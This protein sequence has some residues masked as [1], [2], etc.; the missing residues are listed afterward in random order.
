MN[1]ARRNERLFTSG[2]AGSLAAALL[3]LGPPGSDLAAHV[4]QRAVY[5][6]HGFVLW[7]NF[8]Y[9]GRYSFVTYSVLYYPLAALLGIKLLAVLIVAASVLGFAAVVRH[10]WGA[11]STWSIRVF[12]LVWAC[13]VVSA[14]FPF[15]LGAAFAFAALVALQH[16]RRVLFAAAALATLASS[17]LAFVLLVVV[18]VGVGLARR[19][20]AASLALP[21]SVLV[22]IAAAGV[23][24]QRMFPAHG[25][26]PFSA[27]EFAAVAAFCLIGL[28]LTWTISGARILRWFFAAYL[29][30][31]CA[32]FA[33]PSPIGENIAR[34]RFAAAPLAVLTFSLRSWRPRAVCVGVL[35]LAL[36]W[37][38][39]PLA[40]SFARGFD[41]PAASAAYWR[42]AI[43][44]LQ[45]HLSPQFRVEAVDTT[46]HWPA[47]FFARAGIPIARGWFR[48]EDFPQNRV[49]YARPGPD[50]Y[51]R[52]LR[53]LSVRYV[54]LSTAAPDYSAR[55]EARL[56]RS[57]RSGLPVAF[58]SRNLVIYS[59]P[60]TS[61]L[62]SAPARV[63]ALSYASI[64]LAVP[65]AGSYRLGVTYSPYWQTRQG[66]VTSSADGMTRLT[67]RRPGL[68][69]LRFAVTAAR[70]VDTLEGETRA[71]VSSASA[72]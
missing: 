58:R 48:Q 45:R 41:D 7:N 26:F 38:L 72:R 31:C 2:V 29:V 27:A 28:A 13:L 34:L 23:L 20:D 40:A 30:A 71:C 67:V 14:A 3:W 19:R 12:A 32:A 70:V 33:V 8:W 63:L 61:A 22:L 11:Q 49:L 56:L 15:M 46:G 55:A 17:P 36:S 53:R 64:W 44:Y 51:L 5:V 47:Y 66:C 68:V 43:G 18:L 50:A 65:H 39:T 16:G 52:W 10:E 4:Y 42:P 54:V 60:K 35:A 25:H 62:V 37:N 57:G 1:L 6:Q 69:V 21:A 59:V 9:A 24:V